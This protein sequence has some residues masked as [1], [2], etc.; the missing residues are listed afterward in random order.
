MNLE[1]LLVFI[2]LLSIIMYF[3]GMLWKEID[4]LKLITFTVFAFFASYVVVSG[5]LFWIDEY[6]IIRSICIEYIIFIFC[7]LILIYKNR[8]LKYKVV[9]VKRDYLLFLIILLGFFVSYEKFD[10]SGMDNDQGVYQIKTIELMYGNTKNQL[11][12]KE[13]NILE[14]DDQKR[15]Y[16]EFVENLLGF[17]K[18]DNRPTTNINNRL[19][20]VSGIFHGIP[21]FP[22]VLALFGTMFGIENMHAINSILYLCAMFFILFIMEN[23]KLKR[24]V[25]YLVITLIALSP[26]I[27]WVNKSTLTENGLYFIISAFIY[28]IT[29]EENRKYLGLAVMSIWTYS[30]YHISAFALMPMFFM[31]FLILYLETNNRN[32]LYSNII[33]LVGFYIGIMMMFFVSPKYSFDNINKTIGYPGDENIIPIIS[34]SVL[35]LLLLNILAT[36]KYVKNIYNF[37][38]QKH[39]FSMLIRVMVLLCFILIVIYTMKVYYGKVEIFRLSAQLYYKSGSIMQ[40]LPHIGIISV[41]IALGVFAVPV[42]II[43]LLKNPTEVLKS[44]IS[45]VV[46]IMFIYSV[47][48]FSTFMKKEIYHFYYY[49]R[50]LAPYLVMAAIGIGLLFNQVKTKFLLIIFIASL[51]VIIPADIVLLK[52]KDNSRMSWAILSDISK[53]IDNNSA[54]IIDGNIKNPSNYQRIFSFPIKAM[55]NADIYPLSNNIKQQIDFLKDKYK[56]IYFISNRC[57]YISERYLCLYCNSYITYQDHLKN[58]NKIILPKG[59]EKK[60]IDVVLYKYQTNNLLYEMPKVANGINGFSN[61]ESN[62]FRWIMSDNASMVVYID[63]NNYALQISH[64]GIP[65]NKLNKEEYSF[66]IL[67][68]DKIIDTVTLNE[69]N[70]Q[71]NILITLSKNEVHDGKNIIGFKGKTWSPS[72]YGSDDKRNLMIP[73]SKIEFKPINAKTEYNFNDKMLVLKGFGTLEENKFRWITS[74]NA[75]MVVFLD[76]NNYTLKISQGPDIPL[77]KIGKK[78]FS[79]DILLNNNVIETI[80]LNEKNIK[81]DIIVELNSEKINDGKNIIGFK[82]KTWSPSEYGS[83][84]KRDLMISISKIE[85]NIKK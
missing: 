83:V 24:S 23:L 74:D 53:K 46:G 42:A 39:I 85:F 3:V 56:S 18:Y 34:I 14:T 22:A 57:E 21:T 70:M 6:S 58:T 2:L 29:S 51:F 60:E 40:I 61:V 68:N 47:L 48:I 38:K 84:D 31:I 54:V 69:K 50:Y 45:L 17:Y 75:S 11:D 32:Y 65:L 81:D 30:F 13:Y 15:E 82:G 67:L 43:L 49:S 9:S 71:N 64:N 7:N 28:A 66:D 26:V 8:T 72:E 35:I 41:F 19:S 44:K 63:K 27:Q 37:L 36:R 76:K 20:S 25:S 77:S 62:K 12:F 78:E 10:Y 52:E 79:F 16:N 80:T 73:I 4:I 5:F 33:S 1:L 55:S 59:F